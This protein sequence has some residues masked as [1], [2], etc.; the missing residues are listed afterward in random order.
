MECVIY[1]ITIDQAHWH[2]NIKRY[3]HRFCVVVLSLQAAVDVAFEMC[4][5]DS[6]SI[7]VARI[8]AGLDR[9]V[10]VVPVSF[11][12]DVHIKR[13]LYRVCFLHLSPLLPPFSL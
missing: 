6:E 8:R 2:V 9:L 11:V 3:V 10:P 1:L 7:V 5:R 12:L 13:A 4:D